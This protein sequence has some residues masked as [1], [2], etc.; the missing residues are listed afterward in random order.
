MSDAPASG[1]RATSSQRL[2]RDQRI[3]S[4]VLFQDAYGQQRK[5]VGRFLVLFLRTGEGASLRLGVVTSRKVGAA[6][7]RV[8]ARR[9]LREAW[10][11]NRHRFGGPY[12]VVIVARAGCDRAPWAE[13]EGDLLKA[14]ARA[15]L[16]EATP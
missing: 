14:A 11:R 12:D 15:G 16:M 7:I 5:S 10:R 9:R 8:R 3:R 13:L 2:G 4:P 1:K 6:V